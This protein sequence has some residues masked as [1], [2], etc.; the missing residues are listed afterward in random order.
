SR[1]VLHR[2]ADGDFTPMLGAAKNELIGIGSAFERTGRGVFQM[3]SDFVE[4][5]AEFSILEQISRRYR[6]P[7]SFSLAQNDFMPD[8]WRELLRRVERASAEGL[9]LR[10]QVLTRPI[11]LILGLEATLQPFMM[12]PSY[13]ALA[14]LPLAERALKLRDPELR[15]RM[16]SEEPLKVPAFFAL[17]GMRYERYF[18]MGQSCN[19]EP[20]ASDSVAARA[21]REGRDPRDVL[22][23]ALLEDGGHGLVYVP[24]LNFTQGD[25]GNVREMMLHP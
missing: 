14:D 19:Y 9:E 15:R 11:G 18:P 13:R 17:M 1:T 6:R 5:D 2:T 12:H 4:L 25:L 20:D 21:A 10:A 3:V 23:D 22:L 24:F 16:F 7:A 8:Q